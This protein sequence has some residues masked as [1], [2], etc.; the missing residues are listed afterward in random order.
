M[1]YV[2]LHFHLL[3][4]V[5]DGPTDTDDAVELARAAVADGSGAVVATPHVRHDA[6]SDVL[7]L[8]EMVRELRAALRAASVDLEVHCGGELDH[9]LVGRLSQREL[10]TI[11][12]GPRGARWLLV[13]TPFAAVGEDFHATTA[14]LRERGFGIL[15]A[16]P[17]RSADVILDDAAGLRRELA[18]GALTQITAASLTGAH[19]AEAEL[20]AWRLVADRTA[21]LVASDAHGPTRLPAMRQAQRILDER[22]HDAP[23]AKALTVTTARRLLGRGI[24]RSSVL[25]A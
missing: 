3:P 12:Q 16:H 22:L 9:G 5:D 1:K 7:A 10:E 20:A 8:P 18:A 25:A 6:V 23:L 17:E 11:A 19:G 13:E 4:A 14:E 21:T 15:L 24:E 2:D